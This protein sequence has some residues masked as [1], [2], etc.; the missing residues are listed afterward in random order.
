ME[1]PN[2]TRYD[3]CP[4]CHEQRY[5]SNIGYICNEI[6]LNVK[7]EF[8]S[9]STRRKVPQIIEYTNKLVICTKCSIVFI[10]AL[11]HPLT[12]SIN[13][14]FESLDKK[15]KLDPQFESSLISMKSRI[16]SATYDTMNRLWF[17]TVR[18]DIPYIWL[19]INNNTIHNL[20]NTILLLPDRKIL[21]DNEDTLMKFKFLMVQETKKFLKYKCRDR[22][23]FTNLSEDSLE[24]ALL[25]KYFIEI[26]GW[27][28]SNKGEGQ[29]KTDEWY[30]GTS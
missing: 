10:L 29:L 8:V 16:R 28:F 26:F 24:Y 14:Y 20:I 15:S 13:Y 30:W 21:I 23:D 11:H 19:E 1:E 9:S 5:I 25:T 2:M 27:D 18:F 4:I 6:E 3:D 22:D 17:G 7:D 12:Y